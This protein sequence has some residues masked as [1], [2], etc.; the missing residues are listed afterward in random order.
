M[1][2][3]SAILHIVIYGQVTS[4]VFKPH[5][6]EEWPATHCLCMHLISL[7]SGNL[8][9]TTSCLQYYGMNPQMFVFYEAKNR[10]KACGGSFS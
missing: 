6:P 4:L 5:H 3:A 8:D 1:S 7:G 9:I 10:F 2:E